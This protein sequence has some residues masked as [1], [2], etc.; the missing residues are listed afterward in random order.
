MNKPVHPVAAEPLTYPDYHRDAYGWAMAQAAIIRAGRIDSIDWENVAE[1]IESVGKSE[2]SAYESQ[3]CRILLHMLKWEVQ[4]ERC[5][6]SWWTSI[7]Q[8]RLSA[9][10]VLR[11]NPGLKRHLDE[12]FRDALEDARADA[13]I[14]TGI[15]K[16]RFDSIAFSFRDA[17]ERTYER[18]EGD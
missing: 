12:I 16:T 4:P 18:P 7:M 14:E 2:W 5:G 6:K 3:L 11:K 15:S 9:Q 1:E 10:R 8:G 13:A 17:F